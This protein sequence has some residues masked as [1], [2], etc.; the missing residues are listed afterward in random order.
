MEDLIYFAWEIKNTG[1][2]TLY[3]VYLAP[4]ADCDIGNESD[5][6]ANDV[7]YY[8]TTTNMAYQYQIDSTEVGW[9]IPPGCVGINILQGPVATKDYTLP[10]GRQIFTGDTLGLTHFKVFSIAIDP[11][12]NMEQYKE[13]AGYDYTT[14]LYV[15]F[16]PK[17]SP[18]DCCFIA[19]TGPVDLAPGASVRLAVCLICAGYNY[20]YLNIDDTLAIDS[21]RLKARYAKI[22]YDQLDIFGSPGENAITSF[23]L[24]QNAPNPFSQ[25]TII[26]YQI[27]KSQMVNLKVYNIAGQAVSVLVNEVRKAGSYEVRWD[28]MDEERRKVSNGIYIYQLKTGDKNMIKKMTLIK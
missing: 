5:T 24:C 13:M 9:T 21:L 1:T 11:P 17:P 19:S 18:G 23:V 25:F 27:S 8:D 4:T 22:Y 28:G 16:D 2:D 6:S 14:G 10:D 12:T 26:K 15:P 7:C 20:A 3:N